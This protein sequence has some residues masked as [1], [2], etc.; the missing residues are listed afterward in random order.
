[1]TSPSPCIN[2]CR[3]HPVLALCEGCGRT[4]D[5]IAAWSRLGNADKDRI[6][7][8]LPE[9]RDQLLRAGVALRSERTDPV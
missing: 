9:R 4:L 1:M 3:M 8:A 7:Q 2:V 6:W 5:E